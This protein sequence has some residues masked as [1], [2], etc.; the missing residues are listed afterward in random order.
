MLKFLAGVGCGIGV[1]L[2]IAPK[3]GAETRAQLTRLATQPRDVA[4]EKVA[5]VRQKISEFGAN[6]GRQ[7]A[8]KVMDR[9][10]PDALNTGTNPPGR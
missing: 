2:L 7:A 8:E 1:G 4:R 10:T 5:D 9:V 3:P 6:V